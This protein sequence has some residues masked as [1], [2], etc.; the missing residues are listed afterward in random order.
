MIPAI[1]RQ[2]TQRYISRIPN[3]SRFLAT[4]ATPTQ[5][6]VKSSFFPDEPSQPKI[7]T[8]I[9]GPAS[10][11][12]MSRLNQYQDTRSVFFV[13]GKSKFFIFYV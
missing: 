9:P 8:A 5:E 10:K 3:K 2:S 6:A 1:L 4:V 11:K 7:V 13:A 12:I